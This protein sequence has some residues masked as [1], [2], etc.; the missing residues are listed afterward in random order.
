M[1][2]YL[3]FLLVL[4]LPRRPA[5]PLPSMCDAGAVWSHMQGMPSMSSL[6]PDGATGISLATGYYDAQIQR[7][8]GSLGLIPAENLATASMNPATLSGATY[9]GAAALGNNCSWTIASANSW[10]IASLLL[11]AYRGVISTASA[12]CMPGYIPQID[13]ETGNIF[14]VC[15]PD[16]VCSA[17]VTDLGSVNFGLAVA[18]AVLFAVIG[19]GAVITNV[20]TGR[21]QIMELNHLRVLSQIE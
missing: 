1:R 14:C 16:N 17:D 11:I 13:P 19:V 8:G 10:T 15:G 9:F 18:V 2:L 3:L 21:A 7:Y 12:T 5:A 20:V 4:M 6:Y